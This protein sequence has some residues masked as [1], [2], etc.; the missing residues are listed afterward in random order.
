MLLAIGVEVG[1]TA[2]QVTLAF[3]I[4]RGYSVIPASTRPAHMRDNL[5]AGGLVLSAAQMARIEGLDRNQRLLS[6]EHAPNW[7]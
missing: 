6:P 4:A 2:T 3:L 5:G 1:A 7:D